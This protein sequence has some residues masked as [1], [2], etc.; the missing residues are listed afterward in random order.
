MRIVSR[1]VGVDGLKHRWRYIKSPPPGAIDLWASGA[2][3][4]D[5]DVLFAKAMIVHHQ[6]ALD[7]ARTYTADPNGENTLLRRMNLDIITDQRYE[8]GRETSRERVCQYV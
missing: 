3:V 2:E 1:A 7:M 6:G 4:T 5:Y 8:I